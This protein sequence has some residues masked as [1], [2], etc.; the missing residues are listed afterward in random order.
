[1]KSTL[2]QY[3]DPENIPT[4][5]GGKL[6]YKFG[7]L[8]N[9]DP[10][11]Q[12]TLKWDAPEKVHGA[13]TF[14]TGPVKWQR[15]E[16]GD[17]AAIAVGS[18]N[19]KLRNTKVAT[20]HP[21]K[22]VAQTSL[23]VSQAGHLFR[24]TTGLSTHPPAPAHGQEEHED[25][26]P[27][28]SD[29]DSSRNAS[30][31]G[32][33]TTGPSI[34]SSTAG[35]STT[36]ST[37]TAI[38]STA[39]SFAFTPA[40][41]STALRSS[42]SSAA[43]F[44]APIAGTGAT[45]GTFLNYKDLSLGTTNSPNQSHVADTSRA[46][47]ST[48]PYRVSPH[49]MNTIGTTDSEDNFEDAQDY[50]PSTDRQGT[51]STRYTEQSHTHAHGNVASGTPIKAGT[52][53][54][55]YG[56]MEPNTVG[57]APKEHPMPSTEDA[58]APGYLEQAKALAGQAYGTATSVGTSA[59]AAVGVVAKPEEEPVRERSEASPRDSRIDDADPA[60]VEDYLR[61]RVTT[62]GQK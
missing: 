42:T 6:Q 14:P 34:K 4:Q 16:H 3:I 9:L 60:Q 53:G 35:H 33:S 28:F 58:P 61:S 10:A 17:L 7:D 37:S 43:P 57:Q 52:Q 5:Y 20:L 39:P 32:P 22:D 38:T 48:L 1:M 54:D 46:G 56:V 62:H 11:I 26:R 44:I 27:S 23:G 15:Y 50:Y 21:A 29:D 31:S 8:P 47:T 41:D 59:L 40:N 24:T 51:S 36:A 19:G 55:H 18:Q 49:R 30:I 45:G 2:E 12:K 25:V 13:N